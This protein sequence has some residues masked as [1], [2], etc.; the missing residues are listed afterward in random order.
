MNIN[1]TKNYTSFYEKIKNKRD[2]RVEQDLISKIRHYQEITH[3]LSVSLNENIVTKNKTSQNN[4]IIKETNNPS[5]RMIRNTTEISAE[6]QHILQSLN[7]PFQLYVMGSG[8]YGK[9]TVINCLIGNKIKY[10]AEGIAPKTWKVDLFQ[11][12]SSNDRVIIVRSDGTRTSHNKIEAENI[13]EFEEQKMEKTRNEIRKKV[14][15]FIDSAPSRLDPEIIKEYEENLTLEMMQFSDVIEV[16]WGVEGSEML[17]NFTIVDTPGLFQLNNSG[18]V[19]KSALDYYHKAD[20]VIWLLDATAIDSNN[21]SEMLKDIDSSVMGMNKN[22]KLKSSE[23]IIGLVNKIDLINGEKNKREVIKKAYKIFGDRFRS[24]I[25]YSGK[26]AAKGI[27]LSDDK[28]LEESGHTKLLEEIKL[29]FYNDAKKIQCAKKDGAN[30]KNTEDLENAIQDYRSELLNDLR[31]LVRRVDVVENKFDSEFKTTNSKINKE[32]ATYLVEYPKTLNSKIRTLYQYETEYQQNQ[33][34]KNTIFNTESLENNINKIIKQDAERLINLQDDYISDFYFTQYKHLNKYR[35]TEARK[36]NVNR[37]RVET[38]NMWI[39]ATGNS[40]LVSSGIG[41]ML[42]GPLGLLVG[43]G[44][45]YLFSSYRKDKVIDDFKRQARKV[46]DQL[47]REYHKAVKKQN[48][49][50]AEHTLKEIYKS[51]VG[52]YD[53][54]TGRDNI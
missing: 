19:E 12:E 17:R 18:E 53:L 45:G 27:K 32:I 15:D 34:L 24:I 13:I 40:M 23:N 39:P 48:K 46:T 50:I 38:P 42:M 7:E 10:A 9:S 4:T 16:I 22:K 14:R 26:M 33:Y 49:E 43:A 6:Y 20:G 11:T 3:D 1:L 36:F 37:V 28:I 35:K 25:P 31:E 44:A 41:A 30:Q 52:L 47:K 51:I 54:R 21:P 5:T 29:T 8:K 2:S